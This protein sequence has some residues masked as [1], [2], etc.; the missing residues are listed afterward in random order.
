MWLK[1]EACWNKGLF[2]MAQ[3]RQLYMYKRKP[4][5]KKRQENTKEIH[6]FMSLSNAFALILCQF[7][8]WLFAS[9]SFRFFFTGDAFD[10]ISVLPIFFKLFA[11]NVCF[12]FGSQ[13]STL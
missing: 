11:T 10:I 13:T 4:K 1:I 6:G 5:K 2:R 3:I 9:L 12:I 7:L 8:S